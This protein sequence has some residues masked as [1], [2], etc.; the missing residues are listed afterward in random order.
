MDSNSQCGALARACG[1]QVKAKGEE[2]GVQVGQRQFAEREDQ[3]TRKRS[4]FITKLRKQ[5]KYSAW[6]KDP[7]TCPD[8]LW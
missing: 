2:A 8:L 3:E 1:L 4:A 7:A 5:R 6:C